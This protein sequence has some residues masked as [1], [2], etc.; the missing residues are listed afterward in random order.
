MHAAEDAPSRLEETAFTQPA[1]FALEYA[2]AEL[3]RSLG[4]VPTA[5][6][7]HSVG[8]YVAA[9]VAGVL[10]LE[11]GLRLVAERGR[12]MQELPGGGEM[13]AIFAAEAEVIA[14]IEPHRS[15]VAVAAHN[16][17]SEWVISGEGGAVRAILEELTRRG[18][19]TRRLA[20]SHAF[21]SPLMAP[22]LDAFERAAARV[23]Y[24]APRIKLISNV[25]GKPRT[26]RSSATP[27]TG[28][29]TCSRRCASTRI[30]ALHREG[31]RVFLEVGPSPVL[32]G[33]GQRSVSEDRAPG[34][35]RCTKGR[36]SGRRCSRASA[37]STRG[38]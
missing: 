37:R 2:M 29:G 36:A 11:D 32:I 21:H 6:I 23:S 19:R 17:P 28:G 9:C 5:V 22:M 4:V 16:G 8:E 18:V 27:A 3:W 7:G 34:W 15:A 1:L 25:T 35:R 38:A 33:L 30:L 13:A 26:P 10:G 12:L 31:H 24:A 20:V 14:A